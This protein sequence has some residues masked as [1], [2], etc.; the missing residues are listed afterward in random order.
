[1][2][3]FH[4]FCLFLGTAYMLLWNNDIAT[5]GLQ[6]NEGYFMVQFEGLPKY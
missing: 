1:M 5:G 3:Y 2:F 4:G 6:L